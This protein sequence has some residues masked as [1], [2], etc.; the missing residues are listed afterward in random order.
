MHYKNGRKAK[1]GDSVIFKD[2]DGKVK[3]GT[4]HTLNSLADRCN[5]TVSA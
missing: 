1:E 5:A 3:S 2:F 4:M